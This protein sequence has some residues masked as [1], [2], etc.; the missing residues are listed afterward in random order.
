MPKQIHHS[1]SG[2]KAL[3]P[4]SIATEAQGLVFLSGMVPLH[5]SSGERVSGGIVKETHRVMQ[6]IGAV[7]GDLDLTYDD[8]VKTTIFLADIDDFSAVNAVYAEYVGEARPSRSTVQAGALPGGF[9]VEIECI[10]SR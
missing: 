3:G 7:L 5:P 6:N 8:I 10:A 1:D 2:P 9:L 4:Y